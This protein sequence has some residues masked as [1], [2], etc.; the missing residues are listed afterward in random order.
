MDQ[1]EDLNTNFDIDGEDLVNIDLESIDEIAQSSASK[2]IENLTKVYY[3]NDFL[4]RN[5]A[6]KNRIDSELE[7]LRL[8]IK[9]RKTNEEV[10]DIIL[11]AISANSSN[12]SLYRSLTDV[13]KTIINITRQ[14]SEIIDGLN[15]IIKGYQLEFD[16]D[17]EN[18]KEDS[19]DVHM[20]T[21]DFINQ[22]KKKEN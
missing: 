10:H 15:K 16:F 6:L 2:L 14:I 1:I 11:N 21:K 12:A 20:G 18:E 19:K 4:K 9:M 8:H 5:P 17:K 7:A 22:M 13:Q 3:D